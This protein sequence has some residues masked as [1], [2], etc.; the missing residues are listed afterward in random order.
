MENE[1][2]A[3]TKILLKRVFT[4]ITDIGCILILNTHHW[5]GYGNRQTVEFRNEIGLT[6]KGYLTGNAIQLTVLLFI[7]IYYSNVMKVAL[8]D[9]GPLNV[10]QIIFTETPASRSVDW[11]SQWDCLGKCV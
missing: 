4:D 11:H 3:K 6:K 8:E 1:L 2:Y 5:S 10:T 7:Q 9:T